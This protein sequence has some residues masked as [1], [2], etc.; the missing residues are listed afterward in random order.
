MPFFYAFK[1]SL[2][3][4]GACGGMFVFDTGRCADALVYAQGSTASGTSMYQIGISRR[5]AKY[6]KNGTVVDLP[7]DYGTTSSRSIFV[8]DN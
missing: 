2:L 4:A 6:W 7:S 5:V 8:T 1:T 3:R